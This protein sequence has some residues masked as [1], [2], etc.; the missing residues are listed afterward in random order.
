[1]MKNEERTCLDQVGRMDGYHNGVIG[2]SWQVAGGVVAFVRLCLVIFYFVA[3][4]AH[5]EQRE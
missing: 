2:R 1:M 5:Y 4:F 3:Q